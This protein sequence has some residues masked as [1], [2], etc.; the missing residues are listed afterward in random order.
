VLPLP[1]LDFGLRNG[2][3]TAESGINGALVWSFAGFLDV[4][5]DYKGLVVS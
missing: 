2:Q 5:G 3:H 4:R 1:P